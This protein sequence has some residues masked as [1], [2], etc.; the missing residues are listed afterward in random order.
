MIPAS[1]QPVRWRA[2]LPFDV[3]DCCGIAFDTSDGV[4]RLKLD[5]ASARALIETV[6]RYLAQM[7]VEVHR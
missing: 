1:Y 4:L 5:R 7:P 2:S 3:E 6:S